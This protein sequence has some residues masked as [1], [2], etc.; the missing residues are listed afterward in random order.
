MR[1]GRGGGGG[2]RDVVEEMREESPK[3]RFREFCGRN[4]F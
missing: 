4:Y 3:L 2:G 1:R